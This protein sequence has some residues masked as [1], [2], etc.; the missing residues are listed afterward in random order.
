MVGRYNYNIRSRYIKVFLG[1]CGGFFSDVE[2]CLLLVELSGVVRVVKW[3]LI[4]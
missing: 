3:S 1:S 2:V 4:R